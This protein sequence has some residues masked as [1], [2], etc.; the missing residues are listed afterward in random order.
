[1]FSTDS[2][3]TS[4]LSRSL[5]RFRSCTSA[6]VASR[7]SSPFRHRLPASMKAF[8]HLQ[9]TLEL[10]PSLRQITLTGSSPRMPSITIRI[11]SSAV[12][13]FL[14]FRADF[15]LAQFHLLNET[16][17]LK[18]RVFGPFDEIRYCRL[19]NAFQPFQHDHSTCPMESRATPVGSV[20]PGRYI[21][22]NVEPSNLHPVQSYA[23]TG[24]TILIF[25]TGVSGSRDHSSPQ[26]LAKPAPHRCFWDIVLP[27]QDVLCPGN[28]LQYIPGRGVWG[29]T[30]QQLVL[31]RVQ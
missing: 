25:A 29:E 1:M 14:R 28:T 8:S 31:L 9:W 11:F 20:P 7:F 3:A 24:S 16:G 18:L 12:Y 10:I 17:K 6:R 4:C 21:A 13:R 30:L 27:Q 26:C 22:S 19:N 15:S 2:S 23:M 5:S